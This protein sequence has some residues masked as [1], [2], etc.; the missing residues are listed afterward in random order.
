VEQDRNNTDHARRRDF[1]AG[2][3]GTLETECGAERAGGDD[4]FFRY[5]VGAAI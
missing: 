1:S 4:Q 2:A 5:N 3:N